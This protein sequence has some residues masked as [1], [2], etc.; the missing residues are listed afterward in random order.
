MKSS[1][2]IIILI[3]AGLKSGIAGEETVIQEE[4]VYKSV[5]GLELKVDIFYTTLSQKKRDNP[6]IAFFHG[7]GWVFGDKS[8]FHGACRRYALKGF[9]TFSFQYRLSIN[10][11]GSFPHPEIT[12][13][14]CVKDARSAIRWLREHAESLRID[15]E[16]IVVGGQS[17]GGQL[18]WSTALCNDINEDTDDL[19]I[20]P[21]PDAMLLYSSCFNTMEA[22]CDLIL[23]E[24]RNQIW[25]ISPFHNLKGDLPPAIAFHGRADCTVLYYTVEFFE[26]KMREL[27]NQYELITIADRD[28][29]L[30]EGNEK[31]ARYFDEEIL[32]RTDQFLEDINLMPE[33]KK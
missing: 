28:H 4:K 20:S 12:P 11:D 16:K 15:P 7:G 5:N 26:R 17:A 27:G 29:Y 25:A 30:G 21:V 31:Y 14:E 6:A 10:D 9:V 32:E 23:G 3:L 13:V 19:A 1:V 8:E 24:K 33:D 2:L 22:W 18:T